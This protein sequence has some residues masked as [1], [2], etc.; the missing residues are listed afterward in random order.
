MRKDPMRH[1]LLV[2]VKR[3]MGMRHFSTDFARDDVMQGKGLR[4]GFQGVFA[5]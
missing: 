1:L 5:L 4:A 3:V 2:R